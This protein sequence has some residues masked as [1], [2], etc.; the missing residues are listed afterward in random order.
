M[1]DDL[2]WQ[3]ME[4]NTKKS[5]IDVTRA[6]VQSPWIRNVSFVHLFCGQTRRTAL[7]KLSEASRLI[8]LTK[9]MTTAE[10]QTEFNETR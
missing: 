4:G 10:A 8:D 6:N 3:E 2:A 9:N 5:V 1:L 7:G